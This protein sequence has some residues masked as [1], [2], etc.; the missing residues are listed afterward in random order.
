ME[1]MEK[2][3][4]SAAKVK[5]MRMFL[6]N[7]VTSYDIAEVAKKVKLGPTAAR[8]EV[9]LLERIGF[10][11]HRIYT[12]ETARKRG[13]RTVVSKRRTQ[14]WTLN[15][16]FPYITLLQNFL[17]NTNLVRHRDILR[18]LQGSGKIKLVV[19]AGV[20]IHDPESRVDLLVV[21][22][23]LKR[24]QIE[25]VVGAIESE[26]GK[27][28][29]YAAFDTP[30]FHYRVSMCDKLIRDILDYPH[31]TIIDKIGPVSIKK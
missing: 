27:E 25:N 10:L 15:P 31:E 28:I 1:I 5:I 11:K 19:I 13:K 20:F 9:H 21:G 29:R 17:I 14:G 7:P 16:R 22:D 4:G 24:K 3:F 26:I 30:D 6:F 12:K 2:L 23:S 18:K 8:K